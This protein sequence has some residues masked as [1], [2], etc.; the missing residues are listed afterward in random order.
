MQIRAR[1]S[2]T[3]DGYVTTPDG[4]PA[5]VADPVLV[6]GQSHGIQEFL[7]VASRP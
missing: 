2:M 3:A 5:L 4:W 7:G 6:S 1:M